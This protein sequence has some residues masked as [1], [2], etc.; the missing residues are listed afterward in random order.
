MQSGADALGLPPQLALDSLAL[1]IEGTATGIW[2]WEVETDRVHW[3]P[4]LGPLHGLGRGEAPLTYAAWAEQVHPDDRERI[5][6][7]IA[8]GVRDGTGFEFEFRAGGVE[9]PRWLHARAQVQTDE[10][11]RAVVVGVTLDVT[12]RH[13]R[14]AERERLTERLR[15][16][17][18]VTDVALAHLEL[19]A[20]LEELLARVGELLSADIAKVLLFDEQRTELRVRKA[21]GL[22]DEAVAELRVPTGSGVA[23][24]VA[25][26]G[27]PMILAGPATQ[28]AVLEHLRDPDRSTAGVP[29]HID[30]VVLGVLIV[31]TQRRT[32]DAHDLV[33][34]EL[35]ADRAAR[36]IRQSEL[37]EAA[38]EAALSLQRSLLPAELPIV[39]GLE[40]AARYLP[41]QDGTEVGGDWY[42]LF[43]LADGR[44][45]MVVG[46]V[47]G[48]GLRA[49]ARM[50]TVRT[51]LRAYALE[52]AGPA[53]AL[54]RLDR[55]VAGEDPL[56]FTTL[57]VAF[58][59]PRS[60]RTTVS[61]AGHLPPL[62]V[63]AEGSR[64]LDVPADPPLGVAEGPRREC[65]VQLEP[66]DT[67]VAYTD[68]L[69]E[70][71]NA[72]LVVGLRELG[73]LPMGG[74]AA[75]GVVQRLLQIHDGP[76]ADDD[77]VV[78]AVRRIGDTERRTYR[79]E[80]GAVASARHDVTAFAAAHGASEALCGDVAL[81]VSEACTN[82]VVHAYRHRQG[83]PG[84]MHVE[85]ASEGHAL[86][87]TVE[88]EGC[89]VRPRG[90]SPGIGL[91][92]QIIARTTTSFD[93]QRSPTGGA[94]L[95]LRFVADLRLTA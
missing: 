73:L 78:C 21:H 55:F 1:A 50:G 30:D 23:G 42:D 83:G 48:R 82:V 88:D 33:L 34:L 58:I 29:L 13:R 86:R 11:G 15:S 36:A 63:S 65:E 61:S 19:D 75:E 16:L 12:E 69:V 25:A 59:D 74:A 64:L 53:D 90:D 91:G 72:G 28:D 18:K 45:A 6:A 68:G 7:R 8:A 4:N 93:V 47:V 94:R 76:A 43:A 27:R 56:E 22:P 67:L 3:T 62:L 51:A 52:A 20:L 5:E 66:G 87:V 40:A 17:Q 71:R 44:V 32:Y 49:A 79:A 26:G 37:Y 60:G 24:R 39:P 57:V 14:E 35:V 89:G 9:P 95:V 46:D 85:V 10:A 80:P 77:V 31:S 38:R 81:A 2:M 41:G 70:E 84:D 92:L 54:E